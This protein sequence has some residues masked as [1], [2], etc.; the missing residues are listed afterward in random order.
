MRLLGL[1]L[2]AAVCACTFA[3]NDGGSGGGTGGGGD[4]GPRPDGGNEGD[5]CSDETRWACD[6]EARSRCE[7]AAI[8]RQACERGCLA[9]PSPEGDAYCIAAEPGWSCESSEHQGQ[10]YWTCDPA[11]G[12]LHRCDDEGGTVV[13][14]PD[15]CI[16]G[17]LG[18]DDA[19]RTPGNGAVEMPRIEF[20]IS[21]ALFS[22][23]DVRAPVEEGVAYMLERIAAHVDLAP[24]SAVPDITIRYAPSGNSYC[25]GIAYP[26]S[27]EIDC[28]YGYPIT[29][30]NQNYAVNITIHEIGHIAAAALIAP[31][32][33]RDNCENEGLA[34][35]M[36]G[37]YWMN[38]ASSPV[39]SLRAAARR[40]IDAGRAVATMSDCILASDPYYKVYASFFEYLEAVPGGIEG[41]ANGTVSSAA[42][43]DAWRAWLDE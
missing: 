40:E 43:V 10:Q 36:A 7:G 11:A 8:E 23:S 1:L 30:D 39:P 41:V 3:N 42:H 29:G 5:A 33:A 6:G 19:C 2:A 15:G 4:G 21:G 34:S 24:G 17:P 20:I 25:S 28:P 12:E 38:Y 9:P 22:E 16:V 37:R 31:P 13:R 35:W 27:T 18:T 32:S 14:C 26:D